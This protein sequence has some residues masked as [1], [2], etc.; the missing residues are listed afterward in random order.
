[1]PFLFHS[2][3]AHAPGDRKISMDSPICEW[4]R[5]RCRSPRDAPRESSRHA[6]LRH[7]RRQQRAAPRRVAD[8][9]RRDRRCRSPRD[10]PPMSISAR[11]DTPP[12][13]PRGSSRH[14]A[15]PRGSSR[16]AAVAK[17]KFRGKKGPSPTRGR[18]VDL[19]SCCSRRASIPALRDAVHAERRQP[20][21]LRDATP[22]AP[23]DADV[24]LR[25]FLKDPC[26]LSPSAQTPRGTTRCAA[27]RD[28]TLHTARRRPSRSQPT[29]A[30]K[31]KPD[32]RT[33][34]SSRRSARNARK[35]PTEPQVEL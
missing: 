27:P 15:A 24:N 26:L 33:L 16:H 20:E 32:F 3:S 30:P 6:D 23:R 2:S 31:K 13:A 34:E 18:H 21:T 1:M 28:S 8:R 19:A 25:A 9:S 22:S 5:R 17:Q 10:A 14:A 12:T 29:I 7:G 11:R 4:P 35:A